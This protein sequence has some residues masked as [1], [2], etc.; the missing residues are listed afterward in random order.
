MAKKYR[1]TLIWGFILIIIGVV[2]LLEQFDVNAWDTLWRLWPVILIIWGAWKIYFG[3]KDKAA[4]DTPPARD[5]GHE[6]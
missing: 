3:L 5:P 4:K 2:F 6:I 1:D